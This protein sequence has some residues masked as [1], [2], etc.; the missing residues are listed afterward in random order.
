LECRSFFLD[1]ELLTYLAS[2]PVKVVRD[3]RTKKAI[4]REAFGHDIP[5]ELLSR[6]KARPQDATGITDVLSQYIEE[7]GIDFKKM[8]LEY[9]EKIRAA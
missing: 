5:E 2:L 1:R 7:T 9:F 4:L 6:P 8:L 3:A